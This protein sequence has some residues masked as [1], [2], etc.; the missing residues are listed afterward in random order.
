MNKLKDLKTLVSLKG[1]DCLYSLAFGQTE[2]MV[3]DLPLLQDKPS[4]FN[5]SKDK[6]PNLKCQESTSEKQDLLSLKN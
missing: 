6:C 2:H 1:K 5:L 4:C 3:S